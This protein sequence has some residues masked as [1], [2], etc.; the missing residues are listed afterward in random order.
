M[1]GREGE[2]RKRSRHMWSVPTRGTASVAD[3]SS[4][5]TANSF[6]KSDPIMFLSM[7][8]DVTFSSKLIW[9]PKAPLMSVLGSTVREALLSLEGTFLGAQ[10]RMVL[11]LI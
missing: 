7:G 1:H 5:S 10:C 11:K 2:D 8:G 4:T 3:D 6:L 9:S